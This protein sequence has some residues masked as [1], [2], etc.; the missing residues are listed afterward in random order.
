MW[1]PVSEEGTAESVAAGG[2]PATRRSRAVGYASRY[3][4]VVSSCD[5]TLDQSP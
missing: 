5:G 1:K 4:T 2:S 3:T